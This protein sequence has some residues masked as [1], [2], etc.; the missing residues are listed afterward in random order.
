MAGN[1]HENRQTEPDCFQEE[2]SSSSSGE[3]LG[4]E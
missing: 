4:R 3:M 1:I 2:R